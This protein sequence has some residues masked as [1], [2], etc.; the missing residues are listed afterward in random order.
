M[1]AEF[2]V[3]KHKRGDN[4]MVT[5]NHHLSKTIPFLFVLVYYSVTH[6]LVAS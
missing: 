1:A 2:F 4:I 5:N 6:C 3:A